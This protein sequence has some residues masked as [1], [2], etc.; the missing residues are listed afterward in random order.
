MEDLIYLKTKYP[1]RV[2]L[3]LGNRDI[4]KLRIASTTHPAVLNCYPTTYW[5]KLAG[6]E[7]KHA[8]YELNSPEAKLK[9]VCICLGATLCRRLHTSNVGC[10]NSCTGSVQINGRPCCIRI[11]ATG[12]N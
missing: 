5:T 6:V 2:T 10:V 11:S 9:W 12:T 3:I 8:E 4:N 1:D 7:V